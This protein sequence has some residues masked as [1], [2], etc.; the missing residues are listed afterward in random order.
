M[1][2]FAV[3]KLLDV[4]VRCLFLSGAKYHRVPTPSVLKKN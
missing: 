2:L 4:T 1:R 3:V